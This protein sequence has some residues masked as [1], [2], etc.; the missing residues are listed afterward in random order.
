MNFADFVIPEERLPSPARPKKNYSRKASKTL[1]TSMEWFIKGPIPGTW[2]AKAASLPGHSLHVALAI[3]YVQGCTGKSS[4]I[5]TRKEFDRF[6]TKKNST[7]RA[8]DS[9]V[10]AGLILC[11]RKGHKFKIKILDISEEEQ[12]PE[13]PENSESLFGSPDLLHSD[14]RSAA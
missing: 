4:V 11:Q 5:L 12:N 10:K 13:F 1:Q 8:L 9:L 3:C 14:N 6:S 2:I 7:C